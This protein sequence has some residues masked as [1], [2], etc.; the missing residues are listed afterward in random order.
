[1]TSTNAV[2]ARCGVSDKAAETDPDSGDEADRHGTEYHRSENAGMTEG[3]LE[4]LGGEDPLSDFEAD[5]RSQ[6]RHREHERRRDRSLGT[7]DHPS[8]GSGD[9]GGPDHPRHV[10]GRHGPYAQRREQNGTDE[11]D[12][13]QRTGGGVKQ[14]ALPRGHL[15]PLLGLGDTEDRAHGDGDDSGHDHRSPGRG[16]GAELGPLGLEGPPCLKSPD[17]RSRTGEANGVDG[18]GGNAHVRLLG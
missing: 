12:A 11:D 8:G 2:V 16:Q 18:V 17:R 4:M 9:E 1:M 3:H 7:Q 5:H 10:L 15:C 13:E 14:L 6:Q